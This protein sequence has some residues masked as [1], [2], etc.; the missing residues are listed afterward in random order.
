MRDERMKENHFS[1]I[2]KMI[3]GWG[4]YYLVSLFKIWGIT[5]MPV[6]MQLSGCFLFDLMC[7]HCI[8]PCRDLS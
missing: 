7:L 8:L 1:A 6:M 5:T 4:E 2:D 3:Y